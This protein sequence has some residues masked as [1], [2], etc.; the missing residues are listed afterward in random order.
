MFSYEDRIRAI[1]LYIK[2]GK[3]VGPTIRKLGYPTKNALK[4]WYSEYEHS[5]DLQVCYVR[6]RR[7]YSDEQKQA[8]VQHYQDH[9]RCIASTMKVLGYPC[10]AT[11]TAWLDELDTEVRKRV[12]G[13]AASMQHPL[14]FKNAAVIE[15]CTRKTSAQEIAKKLAVCRPT[16]Y[17][18]KNQ[19]L[20]REATPSMKRQ[21]ESKP[22]PE[23]AELQQQVETLQR[24]IRRLQLEHDLLKKANELLKK[25]MG[26]D[27][28]LLSNREK[29]L[30]VDALKQTYV[31]SELL[32]ELNLARSS[33][34]YHRAQLRNADKYAEVRLA[35]TEIFEC[36]HRCYGYRVSTRPV[37]SSQHS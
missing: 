20:G 29:S 3:R 6:S 16:L 18:W 7:K 28:K 34:F 33:Y 11:L 25:G 8:A 5:R 4:N 14:E 30:L 19:L 32:A 24:D 9:D 36:N 21:N 26:V 13:R 31:R 2:L 10:R 1:K 35:I 15:L 22:V 37:P 17:N 12:V 27:L 23:Q